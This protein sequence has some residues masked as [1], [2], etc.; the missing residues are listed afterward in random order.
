[1]ENNVLCRK[2]KFSLPGISRKKGRTRI[3]RLDSVLKELKK[4]KENAWG[5]KQEIGMCGV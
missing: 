3:R 4:L 5:V 2:I 1:M